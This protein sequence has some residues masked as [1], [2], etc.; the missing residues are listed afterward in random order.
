M[1][2]KPAKVGLLAP[3]VLKC[4]T[5][6]CTPHRRAPPQK[7]LR[8]T[9]GLRSAGG[10]K[11]LEVG[12]PRARGQN[13]LKS[14]RPLTSRT[15]RCARGIT[16]RCGGASGKQGCWTGA[17][18]PR[19]VY[20]RSLQAIVA[21]PSPIVSKS[22]AGFEIASWLCKI[23]SWLSTGGSGGGGNEK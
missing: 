2:T 3:G 22:A 23:A 4:G 18:P 19:P 20:V 14:D 1:G 7:G 6:P 21:R 9:K 11:L 12:R 5:V 16:P 17:T 15:P 8:S 13:L 10:P